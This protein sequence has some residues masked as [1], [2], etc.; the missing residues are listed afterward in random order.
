MHRGKVCIKAARQLRCYAA[1]VFNYNHERGLSHELNNRLDCHAIARNDEKC[2]TEGGSPKYRMVGNVCS[3]LRANAKQS[4]ETGAT[5]VALC[6][7]IG[8]YFINWCR[9]FRYT[10]LAMTCNCHLEITSICPKLK[11][12]V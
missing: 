12:M 8:S 1:K 4:S 7:N 11:S 9:V 5:H 3:S 6:D 10:P 2:H